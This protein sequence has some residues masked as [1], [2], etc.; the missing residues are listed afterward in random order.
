M[1]RYEVRSEYGWTVGIVETTEEA[2][3]LL[4]WAKIMFPGEDFRWNKVEIGKHAAVYGW[5]IV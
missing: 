5:H 1:I 3:R 4:A 2:Y